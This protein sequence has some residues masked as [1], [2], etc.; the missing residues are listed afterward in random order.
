MHDEQTGALRILA[1]VGGLGE[2]RV[3]G[4]PVIEESV[5]ALFEPSGKIGGRDLIGPGE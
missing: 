1:R 3:S 5:A 2:R 4:V